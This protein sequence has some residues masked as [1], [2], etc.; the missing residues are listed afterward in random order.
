MKKIKHLLP[1]LGIFIFLGGCLISCKKEPK[2]LWNQEIKT[3]ENVEIINISEEF[4]NPN[5]SLDEFKNKYP[6][7]QGNIP[8]AEYAQRRKDTTEIRIYQE[9]MKGIKTEVLKVEFSQMFSRVKHYFPKFKTPKIYL[10]SSSLQGITDPIFFR[11]EDEMIFVDISAF[12]GEKNKNYNGLDY[13]LR[14]T[15]NPENLVPKVSEIV[16]ETFVLPNPQENKF[17][18]QMLMSGKIKT[19]QKA[20]LPQTA[21]HL[22]MNYTA[23][24]HN[25]SVANEGNIWNYFVEHDLLFSDD[26]QLN[27]RFLSTA[28]FSKF[29][30]EV[31]QKSSPQVGVFIGWQISKAYFD[32]VPESTLT[33]FLTKNATEIFNQSKYKPEE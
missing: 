13:Y 31:D 12:M 33:D 15:M 22:I 21:E 32:K 23:E 16:A 14:K 3:T 29:Y 17:I 2:E 4:F 24:Q 8:D 7:F 27:E 9:A 19:L 5:T 28:P 10:Y 26:A 30:T 6:W 18:D 11:T 1:T 20:F 25:W